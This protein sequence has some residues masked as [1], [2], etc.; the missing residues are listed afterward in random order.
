[1]D[2]DPLVST[3]TAPSVL[4]GLEGDHQTN[5]LSTIYLLIGLFW[6]LIPL[7]LSPLMWIAALCYCGWLHCIVI[8]S[9]QLDGQSWFVA[10]SL[11]RRVLVSEGRGSWV[12]NIYFIRLLL[13]GLLSP[14]CL[15]PV[16]ITRTDS[17][18]SIC[19][20]YSTET[21]RQNSEFHD[22]LIRNITQL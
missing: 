12:R 20:Y 3:C 18:L 16:G 5:Y 14:A 2:I 22:S 8:Y 7:C 9:R 17:V 1:M 4:I 6:F 11:C 21:E 13:L 10:L 19:R 15:C